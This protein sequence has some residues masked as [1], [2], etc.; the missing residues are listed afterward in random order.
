[1]KSN[2]SQD[3]YKTIL[4]LIILLSINGIKVKANVG[5]KDQKDKKQGF[6]NQT[7]LYA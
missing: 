4:E 1:M 6:T 3:F 2:A 7:N 5:S